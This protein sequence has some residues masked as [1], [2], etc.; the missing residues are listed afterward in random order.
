MET[1]RLE[2]W[3]KIRKATQNAIESGALQT[4]P[5]ST[6]TVSQNEIEVRIG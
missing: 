6:E 3:S 4:I 2:W 1:V 5:T